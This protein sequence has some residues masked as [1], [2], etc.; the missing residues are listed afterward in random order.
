MPLKKIF[1]LLILITVL[2]GFALYK[3]KS[4]LPEKLV[5]GRGEQI[6][7]K[8]GCVNC[9][10][11]EGK[12]NGSLSEFLEPKPRN[13]TSL[14]E[15]KNLPDSLMMYSIKHGVLGASMP[16]HPDLTETQI[17]DL[18]IYLRQF[19]A[20][21]YHTVNMCATDQHIV[22]LK[23]IFSTYEIDIYDS[24]KINA[25]IDKDSLIIN[26]MSPI[27]LI[28]EMNKKNTRTIRN[29]VRIIKKS[30]DQNEVILVT[31]RVHD[32][33]RGKV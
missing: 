23:E 32:C 10:G 1:L 31:V 8:Y 20:D 13:F 30:A 25:E 4:T 26:A 7:Q 16:A 21:Y 19:L 28:N 3:S 12:G 33:I 6:Y 27:H 22:D 11:S 24:R 9:H 17:S 14:K 5:Q 29:R 18:V 2:S 15:M